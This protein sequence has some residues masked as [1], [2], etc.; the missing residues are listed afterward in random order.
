MKYSK[1]VSTKATPQSEPILGRTDQVLNNA[2]GYVF[3]ID[4]WA[5]LDRFLILG[6]EGGTYYATEKKMTKDAASIILRCLQTDGPRVVRRIVEIS[7][8][9]RAPKNDPAIFALA[10]AAKKGD[11]LARKYAYSALPQ[12]CRTATHLFAFVEAAEAFGGWSR[13]MRRAVGDW[14]T[15]K[16]ANA[17]AYQ[18]I[19]YRQRNGWTHRDLLR[20]AKPKA[21]VVPVLKW[22][23]RKTTTTDGLPDWIKVYEQIQQGQVR[24]TIELIRNNSGLPWEAIPSDQLKDPDV[25]RALLPS[26]PLTAL[27]R[28]LGRMT[29][30][31]AIGMFGDAVHTVVTKL[32][33]AEHIRR[34]R[35]HP[36]AILGAL[37]T[38]GAGAGARGSLTWSP[39]GQVL[40]ALNEAFYLAFPNVE[41][42][43]KR[44]LLAL[45]VSGSM[46]SGE[47]AGMP[48]LNPRVAS[49]A[50]ALVTA[51]TEPNYGIVGFTATAQGQIGGRWSGGSPTLTPLSI[52][53][54]QRLDDVIK[55]I[56]SVPMGGTD[57]ALPM[58]WAMEQGWLVDTF[59]VYTD[60]ETWAGTIHPCQALVGYRRAMNINA[61]LIVVGMTATEFSIADPK[62]AGMLDVVGFDTA[63]PGII[64]EFSK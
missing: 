58:L 45:D 35:L 28:N 30:N 26:M 16:D 33:D 60:N 6:C 53:P 55:V 56:N 40:D 1:H 51:A 47:I 17:L 48:G 32:K 54:R 25:W 8:A 23:V 42:T 38:Y 3:K 46:A 57:C 21:G 52:S 59:V 5:A 41:P 10:I 64:A 7:D 11:D 9:G 20:L 43:G 31:G 36:I 2:K 24:D 13:G 63:A 61:K 44:T 62:D 22:A 39:V 50:M 18:L 27:V 29:A 15:K 34:S 49:A 19:K 14:Y 37:A 12:V 4:M